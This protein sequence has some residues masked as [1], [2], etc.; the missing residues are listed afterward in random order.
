M[1]SCAKAS[2]CGQ[3]RRLSWPSRASAAC[4]SW[5]PGELWKGYRPAG[6]TQS[7]RLQVRHL[8]GTRDRGGGPPAPSELAVT[9]ISTLIPRP[10]HAWPC[11]Y[12]PPVCLHKTKGCLDIRL[13]AALKGAPTML[14]SREHHAALG[15][16]AHI[17]ALCSEN[18]EARDVGQWVHA[19]T[20]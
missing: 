3:N 11:V 4:V 1:Q 15:F 16:Q 12:K 2:C 17:V 18:P 9:L 13:E 5:R 20:A 7:V 10:P 14:L 19:A 6:V 8:Q